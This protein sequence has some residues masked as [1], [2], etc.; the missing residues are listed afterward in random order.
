MTEANLVQSPTHKKQI[1]LAVI[2]KNAKDILPRMLSSVWGDVIT[3]DD[4][5][6][7][8]TGSTDGTPDVLRKLGV[9][10]YE[11]KDRFWYKADQAAVD[12]VKEFI[13]GEPHLKVGDKI[14]DFAAARNFSFEVPK[15]YPWIFWLD[16]DD[17]L[18]GK[19]FFT[20]CLETMAEKQADTGF[21]NYLYQVDIKENGAIG[22][23]Y[24]QH[25][26]ERLIKNTGIVEW[27]GMIH[28]TLVPT[29]SPV[30]N[31]D[32]HSDPKV[33]SFFDVVHISSPDKLHQSIERNIRALEYECYR[34]R[35]KFDP[36]PMY[37]LAKA[38]FD[39][40][41]EPYY[42]MAENLMKLYTDG[43]KD[44]R[45]VSG[46][47]EERAQCFD[48][49]GNIAMIH[50]DK[51]L[52]EERFFRA[53][54]EDP[55]FPGAM[56]G[57]ARLYAFSGDHQKANFWV[58]RALSLPA[59]SSTLVSGPA[60][61]RSKALEVIL[62]GAMATDDIDRAYEAAKELY[63]IV[64][65]PDIENKLNWII[66]AKAL[67]TLRL[68]LNGIA[69]FYRINGAS[70]YVKPLL[71]YL[72]PA[73]QADPF[74][75]E[76]KKRHL[77]PHI[78]KD[79][80]IAIFCGP[81]FEPWSPKSIQE[82]G[83]GGS[84][85]A[86]IFLSKEL[87]K[88]GWD[89]TVYADPQEAAGDYE[90]V[91]FRPYY[92]CNFQDEFN[93]FVAWRN[94]ALMDMPLKAKKIYLDIH[95][96]PLPADFKPERLMKLQKIMAKSQ[97][98]RSLLPD[99]PDEKFAVITNGLTVPEFK[100]KKRSPHKLFWGSSYDRGLIHLLKMWPKVREA[101]PDA[102]LEICYGW[103]LFDKVQSGNPERMAWKD[104][105]VKLMD[106]PGITHHGRV[107]HPEL[108]EI[109]SECQVW[110]YPTDFDE[111][112]CITAMRA[113][114]LGLRPVVIN[115]A[116]LKETVRYDY[117]IDGDI[118]D[119]ETQTKYLETLI[120]ALE[121]PGAPVLI[122]PWEWG[123]VAKEWD[124]ELRSPVKLLDAPKE[125]IEKVME[126]PLS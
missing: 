44:G 93:I 87:Q 110:A 109:M 21:I 23:V 79:N 70:D 120:H 28:E 111:I 96:V 125:V 83:V 112:S 115:K 49:L 18:R 31:L 101:I 63:T 81:G 103:Q 19:E 92:E 89:V 86:V 88:L 95:D 104:K 29:G 30:N 99:I 24:V 43:D 26:R 52:S 2:T 84:E 20:P 9:H 6:V 78:W 82:G 14:L 73:L 102:T 100:A 76:L 38:F 80:E 50:G 117:K 53:F 122:N 13:G 98:H 77:P 46:W 4:T 7:T 45:Y 12:W 42:T 36:R 10:V 60:D 105:M 34:L 119:P 37:Y 58:E 75:I 51:K 72:P 114:A 68:Q 107:G 55:K 67:K 74:V 64:Q 121:N 62:A 35:D 108:E 33:S 106:Q 25:M 123:K 48:Y 91:H 56:V 61:I 57:L 3:P 54:K 59:V 66:Q 16:S 47:A 11:T 97:F 69:E 71:T 41:A 15:E 27:V 90:G 8:D 17:I 85:E 116:A 1:A 124:T 32:L 65:H 40:R 113:Q 22:N 126:A 39:L 5:Y 94:I 118:Y